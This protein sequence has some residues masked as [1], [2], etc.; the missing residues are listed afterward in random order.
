MTDRGGFV[1]AGGFGCLAKPGFECYDVTDKG[2]RKIK[3]RPE[4]S[5]LMTSLHAWEEWEKILNILMAI[6]DIPNYKKYFLFGTSLCEHPIMYTGTNNKYND[7]NNIET[8]RDVTGFKSESSSESIEHRIKTNSNIIIDNNLSQTGRINSLR[9]SSINMPDGGEDVQTYL[10]RNLKE[11]Q[12]MALNEAIIRLII[13]G[14]QPLN[15]VSTSQEE[16]DPASREE[17]DPAS[18]PRARSRSPARTQT[19]TSM[20]LSRSSK[21]LPD[22]REGIIHNDVKIDN[23]LFDAKTGYARLIDW[24]LSKFTKDG[25]F[26]Y[27][28]TLQHPYNSVLF[29]PA[30]LDPSFKRLI[31]K[32][33]VDGWN[34]KREQFLMSLVKFS[35]VY[36][37]LVLTK[38]DKQLQ[39]LLKG[40]LGKDPNLN[41]CKLNKQLERSKYTRENIYIMELNKQLDQILKEMLYPELSFN[42]LEEQQEKI[43]EK[44]TKPEYFYKVY[45]KN[46]DIY[47]L[48]IT[49]FIK[50]KML[51]QKGKFNFISD[52]VLDALF[53]KFIMG[54]EYLTKPYDKE[55]IASELRKLVPPS[56]RF[57]ASQYCTK[58]MALAGLCSMGA[59]IA[60]PYFM[61]GKKTKKRKPKSKP[62]P[63]KNTRRNHKNKKSR[64]KNKKN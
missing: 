45:S 60:A 17:P 32:Q 13:N 61:G 21:S 30:F 8:C 43:S 2:E 57:R 22:D 5:K 1:A 14:I 44:M 41:L 47:G 42:K 55:S 23:V 46:A 19:P 29:H 36:P 7:F 3:G 16:P 62:K 24:G 12:F 54:D 33:T 39:M 26:F 38:L 4:V 52:Q 28:F 6:E 27:R 15:R 35:D 40:M 53:E 9:L 20:R 56:L 59:A 63:K 10:S 31:L 34:E 64:R 48:L 51:K 58:A 50:L 11:H 18:R 49:Y 25:P 37:K